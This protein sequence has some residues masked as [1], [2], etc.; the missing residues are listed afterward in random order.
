M[1]RDSRKVGEHIL[2]LPNGEVISDA[3]ARVIA[4]WWHGGQASALYSLSS[5]GAVSDRTA[6]EVQNEINQL[7]TGKTEPENETDEV[8]LTH[9][10][11]YVER[12]AGRKPVESWSRLWI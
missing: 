12:H 3:C 10:L 5:C 11:A 1:S 4:S 8:A 6:W 7:R 9:L 2:A